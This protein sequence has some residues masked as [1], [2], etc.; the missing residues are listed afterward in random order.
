MLYIFCCLNSQPGSVYVRWLTDKHSVY[1]HK[2]TADISL[3]GVRIPPTTTLGLLKHLSQCCQSPSA[4]GRGRATRTLGWSVNKNKKKQKITMRI[5]HFF[6]LRV[7]MHTYPPAVA[8]RLLSLVPSFSSRN[9]EQPPAF[10]E[11][12]PPPIV[13]LCAQV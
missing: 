4:A 9:V 12:P 11:P 13:P 10:L 1:A 8:L 6:S 2:A 3:L 7:Q 5:G